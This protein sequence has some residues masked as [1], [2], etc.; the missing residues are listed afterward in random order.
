[1]LP[2][3]NHSFLDLLD[4]GFAEHAHRTCMRFAGRSYTYAEIDRLSAQV[5]NALL[6]KGFEPGMKGAVYSLNSAE[7]F[8]ATLGIVRA[9]GAWIPINPR[10][11]ATDNVECMLQLETH[12]VFFQSGFAVPAREMIERSDSCRISVCLDE[13]EPEPFWRDWVAAEPA[14]APEVAVGGDSLLSIPQTGGTTGTP[15]GVALSHSNFCAYAYGMAERDAELDWPMWLCAAPMTHVG[16]R[17]ALSSLPMGATFVVLANVDLTRVLEVIESEG[18]TDTFLPPTAVYALLEHPELDRYDLSSLRS[19]A[20]GSSPISLEKLKEA[21]VR[22][23][24][25][26]TGGLGQTECPMFISRLDPQQ[27]FIDGEIAPDSRLASV[28]KAT[29]LS[30]LGIVDEQGQALPAGE[31]GEIAV[32]GPLVSQ[33]YYR[34]PEETAKIRVNGWHLTGDI[35]YLDEEGFLYVVDRKKDMIISG[36]FNVHSAEVEKG[37][38]AMAGVRVAA[39]VGVPSEKWGEE[40]M[41]FIQMEQGAAVG[42]QEILAF[43]KERLGAVKAPKQVRFVDEFPLTPNNKIDKKALKAPFWRGRDRNI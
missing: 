42:E 28:G 31:L 6:A 30:E 13:G 19:L 17:I 35:G 39:V 34:N 11:A 21:L 23:G 36:G 9:G 4:R 29:V 3:F 43:A 7:A 2:D 38:M 40:V 10:N 26:M 22:I 5:A 27:H 15:K 12:A 25:V 14:Q 8:V 37:L 41:A 32:K 16:G 1:M 20:Y 24:P 18:I 33:G